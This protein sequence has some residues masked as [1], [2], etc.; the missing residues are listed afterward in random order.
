ML[1]LNNFLI[2][3]TANKLQLDSA[4]KA[5]MIRGLK[6]KDIPLASMKILVGFQEENCRVSGGDELVLLHG[7]FLHETPT[8][9]VNA[10]IN[11]FE[12]FIKE[13]QHQGILALISAKENVVKVIG[14]PTS[15][16]TI[17]YLTTLKMFIIS[18]DMESLKFIAKIFDIQ[19]ERDVLALYEIV[20]LGSIFSRRT[21]Y[22]NVKRL[23]L[24][25]CI[26]VKLLKD[27][28]FE[29]LV[30]SYCDVSSTIT[31]DTIH[32]EDKRA[33]SIL[34]KIIIEQLSYVFITSRH[35]K[36]GN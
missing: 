34:I 8:S 36:T 6:V 35:S 31:E 26:I 11:D 5:A 16:R 22:K 13:Y 32:K 30:Q 20:L 10:I 28:A 24:G 15:T 29:F 23:L 2:V 18:T 21:M 19:F 14:D 25:E 1:C 12:T 3:G 7:I 33:I 17:F 4:K 27:N 9:L